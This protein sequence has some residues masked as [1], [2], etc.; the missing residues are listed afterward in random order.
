MIGAART[1]AAPA[2][3]ENIRRSLSVDRQASKL[4][5]RDGGQANDADFGV[6][7]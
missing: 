7:R 4:C 3:P 1:G 6:T 2:Q 5:A